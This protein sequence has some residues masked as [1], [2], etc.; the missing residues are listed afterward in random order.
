MGIRRDRGNRRDGSRRTLP[1]TH[2]RWFIPGRPSGIRAPGTQH[3]DVFRRL[4][5]QRPCLGQMERKVLDATLPARSHQ[6]ADPGERPGRAAYFIYRI[7][8][9]VVMSSNFRAKQR[10]RSFTEYMNI[11]NILPCDRRS[12]RNVG[13]LF[14]KDGEQ[15][16]GKCKKKNPHN[17]AVQ[18]EDPAGEPALLF[19]NGAVCAGWNGSVCEP[20]ANNRERRC[21]NPLRGGI[22]SC[23]KG[24]DKAW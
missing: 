11:F 13:A 18:C 24:K 19:R 6:G 3:N 2:S 7:E 23:V 15:Y 12:C 20:G 16:V 17:R 10:T 1:C 4:G 22:R 9:H 8:I 5:K 21:G 14:P